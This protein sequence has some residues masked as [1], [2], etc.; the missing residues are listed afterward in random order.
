MD[1]VICPSQRAPCGHLRL[2]ALIPQEPEYTLE[3]G[4]GR[5]THHRLLDLRVR[6][7]TDVH[8]Q[9]RSTS[10]RTA[11]GNNDLTDL[12]MPVAAAHGKNWHIRVNSGR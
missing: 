1:I 8:I 5:E 6:L 11:I 12:R 10:A 2:A 7:H 9:D 3:G 4:H